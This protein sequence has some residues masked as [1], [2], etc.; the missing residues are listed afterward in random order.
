L[1]T[2][3]LKPLNGL[4]K[5]KKWIENHGLQRATVTNDVYL[6]CKEPISDNT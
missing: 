6:G 4:Y 1:A 2:E 3:Q 5:V